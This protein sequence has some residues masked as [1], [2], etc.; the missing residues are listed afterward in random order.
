MTRWEK[1]AQTKGIT[2]KKKTAKTFDSISGEYRPAYG[3]KSRTHQLDR[4]WLKEVPANADPMEDMLQT[5]R[6]TK[7][8]RV[9]KSHKRKRGNE[10][11]ALG[12]LRNRSVG[13]GTPL[14]EKAVGT[15]A[16][17]E[18]KAQLDLALASTGK[19]TASMGKFDK[20]TLCKVYAISLYPSEPLLK[21]RGVRKLH[22]LPTSVSDERFRALKVLS[23]LG[24][25]TASGSGSGGSGSGSGSGANPDGI[26]NVRKAVGKRLASGGVESGK[27]GMGPKGGKGGKGQ[28]TGK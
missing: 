2:K 22:D 15:K 26:F 17:L 21:S 7:Q 23:K 25:G 12:I 27:G 24:T 10:E 11:A 9:E 28:K 1:F 16:K 19:S 4:N 5:E 20:A 8:E 3:Y 6:D 18:R 14:A 13:I